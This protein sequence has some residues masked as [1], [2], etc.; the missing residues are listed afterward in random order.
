VKSFKSCIYCGGA[1]YCTDSRAASADF[2]RRRRYKCRSCSKLFSTWEFT[3]SQLEAREG[4]S[5]KID[6]RDER[7]RQL[8]ALVKKMRRVLDAEAAQ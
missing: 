1:I 5:R 7:I 4:K 3:D 6:A 8:E 2:F